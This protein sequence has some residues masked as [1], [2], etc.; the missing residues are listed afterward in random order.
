M[1]RC[2]AAETD[3]RE[4]EVTMKMGGQERL[5]KN[6]PALPEHP[7]SAGVSPAFSSVNPV[8]ARQDLAG[9]FAF[10]VEELFA[11]E[12]CHMPSDNFLH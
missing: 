8:F 7:G 9:Q 6:W 11:T 10:L 4:S 5:W 1:W 2:D 3:T 12:N